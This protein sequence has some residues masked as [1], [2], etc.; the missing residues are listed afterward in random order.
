MPGLQQRAAAYAAALIAAVL[1]GVTVR[2][3]AL[4]PWGTDSAAYLTAAQRWADADLFS[5]ASFRHWALWDQMGTVEPPLGH[6]PGPTPGTITG[7]YPLGYP[8]LMAAALRLGGEMAPY[9]VAPVCAGLLVWCA[10]VLAAQLSTPWAGVAAALLV[11]LTPVTLA[12]AILPMSDVPATALVVLAWLLCA[13]RTFGGACAGGL[14]LALSCAVRPNLAPAGLVLAWLVVSGDGEWRTRLGRLAVFGLCSAVGPALLLWS[15][16]V[17]YGH[18]LTPGYAAVGDFFSMTR[19]AANMRWYPRLLLDLHSVVAFAGLLLVPW[20][21][22]GS[23]SRPAWRQPAAIALAGAGLIAANFAVYLPYLTF[24]GWYWLRFMLPSLT[25]LFVLLAALLDRLRVVVA[26]RSRVLAVVCLLPL[27]VVIDAARGERRSVLNEEMGYA[28]IRMMGEYLRAVLPAN[29]VIMTYLQ[30]GAAAVYTGL[31]I[32]R[33]DHTPPDGLS[34]VIADLQDHGL[35]PVLLIDHAVEGGFFRG[36]FDGDRYVRLDWLPRA[37][38]VDR[39][40]MTYHDPQDRDAFV[41]GERQPDDV[42]DAGNAGESPW[43]AFEPPGELIAMPP[44]HELRLFRD[45]LEMV[46][47]RQLQ[48]AP[49]APAVLPDTA[50][51]WLRRYLRLRLHGCGHDD[52]AARLVAEM[53]GK[54]AQPPCRV[55]SGLPSRAETVGFR[56]SLDA[57]AASGARALRPLAGGRPWP[58]T[59]VD[60]EG[61]AVWLQE[62]V[63]YRLD[64]CAHAPAI[65]GVVAAI[66]GAPRPPACRAP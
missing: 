33:L 36:R 5:P 22:L 62:Y 16:A 1:V 9:V 2:E 38:F 6:R 42:I 46:Y 4:V 35:R 41:N 26:S 59:A 40:R 32:V 64:G 30:G 10:F 53:Q 11:A 25:V 17:L 61:E 34:G 57:L 44:L 20:L 29:A 7:I 12:N 49:V 43:A 8:V 19:V 51:L 37:E 13:R 58:L 15:Q 66:T 54:G 21:Y 56:Q 27:V 52:S 3:G 55:P 31:P 60:G 14:A 65:A 28:R 47:R 39:G 48:R 18:P 24:E 63:N 23:H 45:A 50:L